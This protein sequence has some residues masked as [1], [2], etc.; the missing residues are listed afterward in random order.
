MRQWMSLDL[1][2]FLKV[3]LVHPG[4]YDQYALRNGLELRQDFKA[5]GR[6]LELSVFK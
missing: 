4:G 1:D 5:K 6:S 2:L 3:P